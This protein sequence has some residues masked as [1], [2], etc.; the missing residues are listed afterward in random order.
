MNSY[1]AFFDTNFVGNRNVGYGGAVEGVNGGINF[2]SCTFT[3]NYGAN[4]G[5]A[6]ATY[7]GAYTYIENCTFNS[8]TIPNGKRGIN[9]DILDTS[10]ITYMGDTV[11][12]NFI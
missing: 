1:G 4:G 10:N 9:V 11:S 12:F 5:G 8:N 3:S 2:T 7:E 6:Y